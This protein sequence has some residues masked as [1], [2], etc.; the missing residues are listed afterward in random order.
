[1]CECILIDRISCLLLGRWNR[2]GEA[3]VGK[4]KVNER[5]AVRINLLV[6]SNEL[7]HNHMMN[8]YV[9]LYCTLHSNSKGLIFNKKGILI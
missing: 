8:K 9:H 3:K 5:V 1:M 4:S 2:F 7:E 6:A